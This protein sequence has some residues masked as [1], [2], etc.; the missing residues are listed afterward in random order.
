MS[1]ANLS[2]NLIELLQ[3][4]AQ[5]EANWAARYGNL[6]A[7]FPNGEIKDILYTLYLE[8][9]QNH[10]RMLEL[11]HQQDVDLTSVSAPTAAITEE[12]YRAEDITSYL[13][14]NVRHEIESAQ[15]YG[16]ILPLFSGFAD[17]SQLLLLLEG[18]QNAAILNQY[19]FDLSF[20]PQV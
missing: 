15:F 2:Q 13:L 12:S 20:L 1:T 4:A 14:E 3:I 10:K 11:L 17:A 8:K 7:L 16:S 18:A 9:L 19:L 5:E 6:A